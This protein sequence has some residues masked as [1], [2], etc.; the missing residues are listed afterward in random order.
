MSVRSKRLE[1]DFQELTRLVNDSD[2]SITI[3]STRGK[4]VE[5]YE[6]EYKCRGI[7]RLRGNEPIFRD[8]HR[9]VIILGN[10]YP[11]IKPESKFLTPVFH[12]NVWEN[13]NVCLGAKWTMGETLSELVLR[14]GK[15]IQ[16]SKDVLNL[17]SPANN[18][19]KDWAARNMH[20][21]PVDT[22]TFK[23][24]L[25]SEIVWEDMPISFTDL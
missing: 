20:R 7:E 13:L 4:P 16:Y 3:S 21:F 24:T 22:K 9:V 5:C 15:I 14:I 6:L 10:D 18:T 11:R 19:A 2:G 17:D 25:S 8:T 12:P 1:S 23:S